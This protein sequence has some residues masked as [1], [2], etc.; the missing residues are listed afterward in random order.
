[1]VAAS[2]WRVLARFRR[3]GWRERKWR[4]RKR[5]SNIAGAALTGEHGLQRISGAM[6]RIYGIK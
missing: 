2:P 6:D 5:Y 1:M 3:S 4:H